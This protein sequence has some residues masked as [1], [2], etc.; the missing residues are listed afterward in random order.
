[1]NDMVKDEAKRLG[2]YILG[3]IIILSVVYICLTKLMG[4]Y[5]IS[6][7]SMSPTYHDGDIVKTQPVHKDTQLFR[8]DTVI[9]KQDGRYLVKRIIGIPND[10]VCSIDGQLFI[11]GEQFPDYV[12]DIIEEPGLLEEYYPVRDDEYFVLG[13]NRNASNDSRIFG[14][15]KKEN[16]KKKVV[17]VVKGDNQ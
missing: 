10:S 16:I 15:V 4:L 6:G 12:R 14:A 8:G 13:D 5:I 1:M 3:A 11:N 17:G 7:E 9:F 2:V